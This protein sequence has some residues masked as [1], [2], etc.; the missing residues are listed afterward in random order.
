[1]A[2]GGQKAPLGQHCLLRLLMG[3]LQCLILLDPGSGILHHRIDPPTL[4]LTAATAI[5]LQP[6]QTLG[7]MVIAHGEREGFASLQHGEH[8]SAYPT[9]ILAL[10]HN[11]HPFG[12]TTDLLTRQPQQLVTAP[13]D[14]LDTPTRP[15]SNIN[16]ST[17]PGTVLVRARRRRSA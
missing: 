1:M 6:A 2:D 15:R 8:L 9:T 16:C 17:T 12:L 14:K 4:W 11:E 10:Q 7:R 13:A 3:V 5:E